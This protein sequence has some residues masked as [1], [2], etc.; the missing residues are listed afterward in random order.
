MLINK[1]REYKKAYVDLEEQ[2]SINFLESS[3]NWNLSRD[4]TSFYFVLGFTLGKIFQLNKNEKGD[5][6]E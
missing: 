2:I 5:K 4:E 3:K 6:D 1:L